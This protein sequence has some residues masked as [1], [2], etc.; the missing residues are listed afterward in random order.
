M[1]L[2]MDQVSF[3]QRGTEVHMCKR[4]ARNPGADVRS[5]SRRA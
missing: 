2:L 4:L 3:E 1:R 5:D